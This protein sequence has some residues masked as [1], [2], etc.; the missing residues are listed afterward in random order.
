MAD[1]WKL[2][3]RPDRTCVVRTSPVEPTLPVA[4]DTA[5]L[6]RF[7]TSGWARF[8]K[9]ESL[10]DLERSLTAA[11][12]GM[13]RNHLASAMEVGRPVLQN[14]VADWLLKYEK[15]GDRYKVL[16]V[17]PGEAIPASVTAQ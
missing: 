3:L 11:L 1:V 12:A 15:E 5:T 8:D 10:A 13:S 2:E 9:H 16:I 6:E 17:Y 14:W 4:F 7:T